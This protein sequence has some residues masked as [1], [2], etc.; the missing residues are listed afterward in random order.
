MAASRLTFRLRSRNL[1]KAHFWGELESRWEPLLEDIAKGRRVPDVIRPLVKPDEELY[2]VDL[3]M[4][5]AVAAPAQHT[6]IYRDLAAPYLKVLSERVA[7]GDREQRARAVHT[8]A[9]L[10]EQQYLPVF[11]KA[12]EDKSPLVA[13][14]SARALATWGEPAVAEH[15]LPA[16][17]RFEAW[18]PNVLASLL[19]SLGKTVAPSLR[20]N[21]R[22][23]HHSSWVRTIAM[24]ALTELR[25]PLATPLAVEILRQE[26][27]INLQ[28]AAIQLLAQMG[29]SEHIPLIRQ[30]YNSPFFP[31]RLHAIRALG[32]LSNADHSTFRQAL[33]DPSPWVAMEAAQSLKTTG[34]H[35]VLHEL[36]LAEHPRSELASQMLGEFNSLEFVEQS[37]KDPAFAPHVGRL[38]LQLKKH[39]SQEVRALVIHLFFDT[40]TSSAV[41]YAMA[42]ELEKFR[43]Y[44][45]F[46]QTLSCLMMGNFP[47]PLAL[48]RALKSF[49]NPESV[50]ILMQHYPHASWDERLEIIE[51]LG[52]LDSIESLEFLSKVYNE[53]Q[54]YPELSKVQQNQM[55]E[56]LAMALAR[57]MMV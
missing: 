32:I 7:T 25:D 4:R 56:R 55:Q 19:V 16:L 33:D 51:T 38:F 27:D 5:R 15:L 21:L 47:D 3:I 28:I 43:D 22:N 9:V 39:D 52:G 10:G 29:G 50:P 14:L 31:V 2:F 23:T 35:R 53:L 49:A 26:K 12:L 54:E 20:T 13:L 42:T 40:A 1:H 36:D 17:Q 48:I 37:V 44:Q 11:M 6:S 57:R 46:Y 45:F 18:N 34:H 8:L 41:R 30:R 24:K